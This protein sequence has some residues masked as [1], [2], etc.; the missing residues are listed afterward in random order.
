MGFESVF[1]AITMC[2]VSIVRILRDRSL[3]FQNNFQKIRSPST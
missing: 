3:F 2:L 1:C